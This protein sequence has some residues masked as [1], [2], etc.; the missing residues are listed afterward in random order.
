MHRFIAVSAVMKWLLCI[1]EHQDKSTET[2]AKLMHGSEWRSGS[3][4]G[5]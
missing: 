2:I 4:E 5:P 1:R 3:K